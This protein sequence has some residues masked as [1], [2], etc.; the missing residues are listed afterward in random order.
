MKIGWGELQPFWVQ[1]ENSSAATTKCGSG[2]KQLARDM[3]GDNFIDYG[4]LKKCK[5]CRSLALQRKIAPHRH[6]SLK[7]EKQERRILAW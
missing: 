3:T 7:I 1:A 6:F 4:G 2:K 5:I